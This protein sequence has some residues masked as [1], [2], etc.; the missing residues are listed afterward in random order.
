MRELGR[1]L[2]VRRAG[3]GDAALLGDL[4]EALAGDPEAAA[5]FR[6]HPLT[7]GYARRLCARIPAIRDRYY[8]AARGG[9]AAAYMMLRGWDEGY[10]VPSF[11]VGVHPAFRGRGVGRFLLAHA[12]PECR[13]RGA[14]R[15]RLPVFEATRPAGRLYRRFGFRLTEKGPGELLGVLDLAPATAGRS[16]LAVATPPSQGP[17]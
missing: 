9:R 10:A 8:L 17:S 12:V 2:E 7:R 13:A 1:G 14:P 16:L 4:F 6:P 11:G 5:F 15:I 3:G